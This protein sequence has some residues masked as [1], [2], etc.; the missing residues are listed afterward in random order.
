M[1]DIATGRDVIISRTTQ[2]NIPL[3]T[4]QH[5]DNG[6][7]KR[8]GYIS[9]RRLFNYQNTI[10]LADRGVFLATTQAEDFHIGTR[11]KAL[12]FKA[13]EQ[14]ENVRLFFVTAINKLQIL[15]T[16][17]LVNATDSLP[18]LAISLPVTPSGE[19][20][21]DFMETYISAVKKQT[22][23][24]LLQFITRE[25]QTY[26]NVINPNTPQPYNIETTTISIAAEASN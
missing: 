20:D 4:H 10:S 25:K 24:R 13:G 3:I 21:Y 18:F 11:V 15:F 22:I 7:S 14:S 23:A 12:S 17:Y 16:D 19:I 5:D 8:I 1:F 2:G 9:D 26:L 6:I